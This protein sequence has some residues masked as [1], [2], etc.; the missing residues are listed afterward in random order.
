MSKLD[1]LETAVNAWHTQA[2]ASLE[3]EADFLEKLAAQM[4]DVVLAETTS[5][6]RFSEII[7]DTISELTE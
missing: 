4:D 5:A 6:T 3:A 7:A 2:K 1:D